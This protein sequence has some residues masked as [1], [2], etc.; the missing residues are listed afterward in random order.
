[1]ML[2]GIGQLVHKMALFFKQQG[3]SNIAAV[4]V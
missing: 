1:M 4:E 3:S 2:A